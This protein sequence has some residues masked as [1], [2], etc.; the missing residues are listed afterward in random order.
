M[1]G[2]TIPACGA[3]IARL[4]GRPSAS[5]SATQATSVNGGFAQYLIASAHFA[6]RLHKGTEFAHIAPIL[7]AGVTTYKG[8]KETQA[9]PGEWVAIT[10]IGGLGHLAIQ[11]AKAMGLHVAAIDV[12][13][14]KLALAKVVGA[15]IAVNARSPQAI[16]EVLR[17]AVRTVFS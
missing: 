9:R 1:P 10:G 14:E 5:V 16:D 12:A 6:A 11:Y 3:N 2:C 17:A 4:A 8:L 15:A 13:P 7:C